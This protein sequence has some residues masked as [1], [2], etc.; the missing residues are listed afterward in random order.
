MPSPL[1]N[2]LFLTALIVPAA[3]YI[4]GVLILMVSLVIKH[5]R[6]TGVRTHSMEAL[7]H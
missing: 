6:S 7:A 3:M 4:I 1:F 5:F 2:V